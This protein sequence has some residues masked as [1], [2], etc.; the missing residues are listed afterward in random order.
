MMQFRKR[1][2]VGP[3][4]AMASSS[5]PP[6]RVSPVLEKYFVALSLPGPNPSHLVQ[7]DRYQGVSSSAASVR[8]RRY[9]DNYEPILLPLRP[10]KAAYGTRIGIRSL[11]LYTNL[12]RPLPSPGQSEAAAHVERAAGLVLC[13]DQRDVLGEAS[14][15]MGGHPRRILWQRLGANVMGKMPMEPIS[16]VPGCRKAS[17]V[18]YISAPR[19]CRTAP[20]TTFTSHGLTR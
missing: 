1:H 14:R 19:A 12:G 9:Y 17:P 7:Q 2:G 5:Y 15:G 3:A 4:P 20:R 11:S 16:Q 18:V 8:A 10:A 13:P 6:S